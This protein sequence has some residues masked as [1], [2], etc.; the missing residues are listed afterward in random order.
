[1]D[2]LGSLATPWGR[3]TL[4][5]GPRGLRR[6]TLDGPPAPAL[7]GE[8]AAA[9][10]GY[11][12]GEPFP[13]L[14]VELSDQPAFT[15]R[16]LEACRAIPFGALLSYRQLAELVGCPRGARAVGGAL[17]RNPVPIVIPCHR[18]VGTSGALTGFLGGLAWKRAL[19]AH[20]GIDSILTEVRR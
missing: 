9:F 11:L 19:L 14:P 12:R 16:V 4:T 5:V 8:W 20:E 18:V 7:T 6:V 10:A 13:A 15:R 17:G 1:M 3:V 2:T